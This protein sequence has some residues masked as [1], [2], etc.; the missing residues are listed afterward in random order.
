MEHDSGAP[1]EVTTPQS[2]EVCTINIYIFLVY[3][4]LEFL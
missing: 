1:E 4:S 3:I 2:L